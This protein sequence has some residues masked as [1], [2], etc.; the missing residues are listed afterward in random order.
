M[1]V[2]CVFP[3]YHTGGNVCFKL[4]SGGVGGGGT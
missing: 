2:S 3:L 4:T 1:C